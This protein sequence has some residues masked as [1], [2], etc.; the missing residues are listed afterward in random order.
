ML[1]TWQ[2]AMWNVSAGWKQLQLKEEDVPGWILSWEKP[3]EYTVKQL[4]IRVPKKMYISCWYSCWKRLA[5]IWFSTKCWLGVPEVI[6]KATQQLA[7]LVIIRGC[8]LTCPPK[9][10][11]KC[12]RVVWVPGYHSFPKWAISWWPR[13]LLHGLKTLQLIFWDFAI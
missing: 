7:C 3:E 8:C 11:H 12:V 10:S 5:L 2:K 6:C 9:Q 13:K 4:Q 1:Q